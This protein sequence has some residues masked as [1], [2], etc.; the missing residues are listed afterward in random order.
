[1][2]KERIERIVERVVE[3]KVHIVETSKSLYTRHSAD[4]W[5]IRIREI[6]EAY[7]NCEKIEKLFSSWL[8]ENGTDRN[9][10]KWDE[11]PTDPN[12]DSNYTHIKG[13]TNSHFYY[14]VEWKG[15]KDDPGYV[16]YL[17]S[18]KWSSLNEWLY[19]EDTLE[20]IKKIAKAH[21]ENLTI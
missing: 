5:S 6:D 7:P 8:T 20:D 14:L 18:S 17:F 21:Y 13:L 15:W 16:L 9:S 2:M 12:D 3:R 1:M 19:C 10:I 4:N 11:I